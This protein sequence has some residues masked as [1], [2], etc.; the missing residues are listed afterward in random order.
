MP[1]LWTD[2]IVDSLVQDWVLC[3]LL[4]DHDHEAAEILAVAVIHHLLT[5]HID[6][7]T[8]SLSVPRIGRDLLCLA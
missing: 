5:E 2:D 3:Q 4:I 7:G 6:K 8:A 1:D